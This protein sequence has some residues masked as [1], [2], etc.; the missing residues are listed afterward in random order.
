MST[1]SDIIT[2][3]LNDEGG[4]ADVGD[5]KGVTRY[6]QTSAWLTQFHL[7]EPQSRD[8]AAVN[9]M[10]WLYLTGLEKIVEPGDA[11]A[12]IIIDIAVMS[13]HRRAIKTLQ[14][15]LGVKVDG[16]LGVQTLDALA[17]LD[18]DVLARHVIAWDMRYE[19]RLIQQDPT[20]A[21]YAAG[22]ADRMAK[23]V[24]RLS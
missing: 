20:R 22:W 21:R 12:D 9:Y 23:H 17:L 16:V 2:R 11:L 24:E 7:P 1:V 8:D 14:A 10:R 15:L 18:R 3:L 5:G 13:D 6:G 19:G 4:V